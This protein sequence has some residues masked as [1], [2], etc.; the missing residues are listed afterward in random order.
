[1]SKTI[2]WF[3]DISEDELEL[4]GGK[5]LNLGVMY[6]LKLPVPPVFVV[7]TQAYKQFLEETKLDKKIYSL[8]KSL[9]IQDTEKLEKTAKHIQE[10]MLDRDIPEN[11]ANEIKFAYENISIDLSV[12]R[13]ASKAA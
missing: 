1:M 3:K 7:T 8:L 11:I 5:A 6:N 9:D 12:Y 4:V 2:V 13:T 10:L